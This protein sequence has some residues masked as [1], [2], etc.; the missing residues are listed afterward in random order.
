[1]RTHVAKTV[2]A[3]LALVAMVVLVLSLAVS[4]E[5][6]QS[7]PPAPQCVVQ[8]QG[9]VGIVICADIPIAQI[10]LPTVSVQGPTV[11]LPP[12]TLPPITVPGPTRTVTLPPVVVPGGNET[13]TLPGNT[14]TETVI[15]TDEETKTIKPDPQSSQPTTVVTETGTGQNPPGDGTIEDNDMGDPTINFGDGHTTVVEAAIGLLTT[16]LLVGLLLL[17]MWAGYIL[18]YKDKEKKDTRFLRALLDQVR[19]GKGQHR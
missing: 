2:S 15:V 14:V 8:V 4:P 16:L 1:M 9:T 12:V 18:G 17:T 6:A 5:P 13:V 3:V 7:A 19:L 11:T 10:P